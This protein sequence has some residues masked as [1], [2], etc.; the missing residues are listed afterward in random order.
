MVEVELALRS[1][2]VVKSLVTGAVNAKVDHDVKAKQIEIQ[3]AILEVHEHLLKATEERLTLLQ[4]LEEAGRRLR[5][6]EEARARLDGYE[7]VRAVDGG[8]L[9]K[10]KDEAGHAVHHYAC[11]PCYDAGKVR[12]LQERKTGSQQWYYECAT[13]KFSLYVGPDDPEEPIQY[14]GRGGY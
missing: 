13:C 7:L 12:V 10:S 6:L 2:G 5:E 11:P 3:S 9:Y 1:L 8:Y 14:P 4:R